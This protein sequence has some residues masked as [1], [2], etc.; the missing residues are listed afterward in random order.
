[1]TLDQAFGTGN[2]SV[3][4][5]SGKT[6]VT[7]KR[8]LFP[9]VASSEANGS[10]GDIRKLLYGV[11]NRFHSAITTVKAADTTLTSTTTRE[12]FENIYPPE[13]VRYSTIFTFEITP[14]ISD[15]KDEPV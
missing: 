4:T 12:T 6:R 3:S 15:V 1:M 13:D 11:M 9:L 2:V 14:A 5:V 10:T 8:T 7:M